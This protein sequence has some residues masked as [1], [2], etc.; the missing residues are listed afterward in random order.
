MPGFQISR[1][2]QIDASPETVFQKVI[3]F[4]AWTKWSPWLCADSQA[5]VQVSGDGTSVG[6]IY[7]W[8][9]DIVGEGEIEHQKLQS[10]RLVEDELRFVKPFRSTS[11]VTF[12][13]AAVGDATRVTWNMLGSLP[14]F[15]FWMRP[16]METLVGMDYDR[17]LKMLKEWIE[18]GQILSKTEIH[19]VES[20][21]PL[22]MAGVRATCPISD[23]GS[24]MKSAFA[25]ATKTLQQHQLPTDGL[26]ISVYHK[27]DFKKRTFDYTSG[28]VL[29]ATAPEVA[30]VSTWSLPAV[31]ALRVEHVGD[32]HHLGN[33][34]SAANQYA[35]YKKLKQG[36]CGTY[37]IYRNDPSTTPAAELRTDIYLPLRG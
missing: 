37:E 19:G 31:K 10:P 4:N 17:G 26:P 27:L 23:I 15:M 25:E 24:S 14:W 12:E 30:D 18:T 1:A 34:W 6:S 21:G 11:K 36:R 20:V 33:A 3:D 16:M 7:S 5:Q 28:F 32:Y 13:L 35:R 22:R 29:P 2:I 9:G 8:K